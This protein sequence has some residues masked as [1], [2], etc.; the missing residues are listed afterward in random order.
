MYFLRR[1]DRF[2]ASVVLWWVAQNLWNIS[3]YVKDAR[4][5]ALPLV[6]GGEHDWAYL[7]GE[8]G[9][10][11]REQGIGQA[12]FATGLVLFF[13]SVAWGLMNVRKVAKKV[14]PEETGEVTPPRRTLRMR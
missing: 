4:A 12:F 7:L 11:R 13:L 5:L 10:L 9:L 3:V 2:A 1:G 14:S 8:M 6:G